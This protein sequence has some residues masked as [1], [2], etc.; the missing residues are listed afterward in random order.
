M[1]KILSKAERV[2]AIRA[3]VNKN[4]QKETGGEVLASVEDMDAIRTVKFSTGSPDLDRALCGG[5][6][7]GHFT[8]IYGSESTGKSTIALQA[9]ASYQ[10]SY[11][12]DIVGFIDSEMSY[13]QGY[14]KALGVDTDGL[15]YHKC[16]DGTMGLRLV[17]ELADQGVGMLVVDSVAALTT[18]SDLEGDIG[19]VTVGE[20]ARM[21]SPAL[22]R[23]NS[24]LHMH[25]T[26]VIWTNQIRDKIGAMGPGEHTTTPGGRA[27]RFYTSVRVQ[28]SRTGNI[29]EGEEVVGIKV[30]AA[31][32]KNKTSS[33]FT[34]AEFIISFGRGIDTEA[35]YFDAALNLGVIYKKGARFIFGEE[36]L[37]VGRPKSVDLVRNTPELLERIKKATADAI[38][39][40]AKPIS[41]DGAEVSDPESLKKVL[42][43]ASAAIGGDVESEEVKVTEE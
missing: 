13:D 4:F 7:K 3:T 24:E 29:K 11:P 15:I 26:T 16:K 12:D 14:A 20:Q 25:G 17:K 23:L 42:K 1:A 18:K 37:G 6:P 40:G 28:L 41:K 34:V 27:M 31:V 2:A 33:P 8:E 32:K 35:G 38:A 5:W 21:M 10:K 43:E 22:R 9:I 36:V 39:A 19:D 30:K